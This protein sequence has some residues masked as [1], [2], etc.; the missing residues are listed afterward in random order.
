MRGKGIVP[1][2]RKGLLPGFFDFNFDVDDFFDMFNYQ[3]FRADLKETENEYILE[4]DL[5]GC[6]KNSIE[7]VYDDHNL[8]IS[9]EHSETTEESGEN[10]IHKE[11]RRGSFSRTISVPEN[12][13]GEKI[14][15]KF[16]NGVLQVI[17]PKISPSK[18]QGRKIDI[19]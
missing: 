18:P 14:S 10:Y 7:I 6:D 3:S 2:R 17:M 9:A 5:P 15:A 4:A 19:E 12:V 16:E 13:N 11:R 1:W 8:T